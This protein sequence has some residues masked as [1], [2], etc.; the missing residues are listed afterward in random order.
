M[1]AVS[2][3]TVS[4]HELMMLNFF[5]LFIFLNMDIIKR[6]SDKR[7]WTAF[8]E[9]KLEK[10]NDS[11]KEL[12][13]LKI[14]VEREEY[15]PVAKK[16][17]R[18]E[19]LSPPKK[20]LISKSGSTKKRTVYS[21]SREENYALKLISFM[22]KEY[23]G[24]FAPNLYSFRVERG[25]KNAIERL[26][27]VKNLSQYYTY[28]VDISSYFNSA[29]VAVT[30]LEL[31]KVLEQDEELYD[32]FNRLLNDK[33]VEFDGKIIDEEKGI[34]PGVPTANFLA[35][36]YLRDLDFYFMKKRILY[37]RY[38][39]DIIVFSKTEEKLNEYVTIIKDFLKKRNLSINHSK[40]KRTAPSESWDF[41][42]YS[43]CNG[44]IDICESSLKKLKAKMK[45]KMRALSR[46]AS[47]K[48]LPN[49]KAVVAFIRKF[50]AKF[51]DNPIRNELTWTRW[52]FPII[53]TTKGLET[54]DEYMQE[55]I[56][57]LATGK[58]TNAKYA[59]R[60]EQIKSLGY[61][62][63]V[64]EYYKFKSESKESEENLTI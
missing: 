45:R 42:G 48:Q 28:K 49:E 11:K 14:F 33:R 59:F 24:V 61:R 4:Y 17:Q 2:P 63:L 31:K 51:F 29:N 22:L 40:E 27:S 62:N 52:Y 7:E 53:N 16:I 13:D 38:S 34:L 5:P 44:K 55:C 18:G 23:D 46:W 58:R 36:L 64:H 54:I 6:L 21:F 57:C 35:N 50:N 20:L 43:Y 1:Q 60:Y 12:E 32:F 30:M 39:D 15:I 26:Q 9:Y 10:D 8:L 19:L 37:L 25:V 56:R 3:C 47:K 41:L